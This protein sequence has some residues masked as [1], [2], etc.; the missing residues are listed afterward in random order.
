MPRRYSD[1]PDMFLHYNVLS[2]YGRLI[3]L[4]SIFLFL[5]LIIEMFIRERV[6][7][8]TLRKRK[9]W[10]SSTPPVPHTFN[11]RDLILT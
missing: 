10:F 3:S 6:V 2:R 9:E 1:Y 11:Q 7:L 4:V 5:F 8:Y